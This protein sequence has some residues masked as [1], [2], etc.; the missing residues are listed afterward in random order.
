MGQSVSY[1]ALKDVQI[2]PNEE[3]YAGDT[4]HT[5]IPLM[6]LLLSLLDQN[7]IKTTLTHPN[8]RTL[9]ASASQD[10]VPEEVAVCGVSTNNHVHVE[11]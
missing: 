3:E 11:V 8:R 5:V 10:S 6:N 9:A 7:L 4:V 2:N 1:A